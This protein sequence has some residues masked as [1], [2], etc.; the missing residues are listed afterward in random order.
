[1]TKLVTGRTELSF[2]PNVGLMA[3]AP[4]VQVAGGIFH[5]TARGNR[6]Q[7][8][9]HD[10]YD[11]QVFLILRDRIVER[12]DWR[13][14]AYCLMTNHFH[15]LIETPEPTLSAGMHTLNGR[16][17]MHFN[18]RHSFD[19]HLFERRFRSRLIETDEDLAGVLDY[20]AQNPVKAGLCAHPWQWR[21]SSFYGRR[22]VSAG[23]T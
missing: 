23:R 6:R 17:A 9:Y 12:F 20:I 7:S 15:L 1:V 10:D 4:R 19:G 3:R 2:G 8:I 22:P 13:Q 5:V 14:L 11:R 18:E 21:W 16:Y